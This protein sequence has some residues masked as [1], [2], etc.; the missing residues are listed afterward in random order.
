MNAI[1]RTG[2]EVGGMKTEQLLSQAKYQAAMNMAVRLL[3]N[4]IISDDEYTEIEAVMAEKYDPFFGTLYFG[5][6]L[7][8]QAK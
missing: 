6:D 8:K 2:S 4:G 7:I 5:I 1:S 3:R